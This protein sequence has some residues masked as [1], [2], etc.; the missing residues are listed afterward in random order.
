MLSRPEKCLSS[1][2]LDFYFQMSFSWR[3]AL[4]VQAA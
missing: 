1:A 2:L 3:L 4:R